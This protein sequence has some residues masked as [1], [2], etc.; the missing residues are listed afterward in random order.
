MLRPLEPRQAARR[1]IRTDVNQSLDPVCLEYCDEVVEGA[2]RVPN[3][4]DRGHRPQ[5]RSARA[6]ETRSGVEWRAMIT[7][8]V[9]LFLLIGVPMSATGQAAPHP[10]VLDQ[11]K[12]PAGE[13]LVIQLHASG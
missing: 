9:L 12:L 4:I 7:R 10:D 3:G 2:R 8:I 13:Q 11:I 6:Q 1:R 5:Y